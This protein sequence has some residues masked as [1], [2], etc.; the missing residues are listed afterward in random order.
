MSNSR[1]KIKQ[2]TRL[3]IQ[4]LPYIITEDVK[5]PL[6]QEELKALYKLI[7]DHVERLSN[8][9]DDGNNIDG[10]DVSIGDQR[11]LAEAQVRKTGQQFTDIR[12]AHP[13]LNKKFFCVSIALVDNQN[14]MVATSIKSVPDRKNK[15]QFQHTF[16]HGPI[17]KTCQIYDVSYH[18]EDSNTCMHVPIALSLQKYNLRQE[19]QQAK[20]TFFKSLKNIAAPSDQLLKKIQEHGLKVVNKVSELEK[21]DLSVSELQ[22]AVKALKQCETTRRHQGEKGSAN[23]LKKIAN[24]IESTPSCLARKGFGFAIQAFSVCVGAIYG[25]GNTCGLHLISIMGASLF[26]GNAKQQ[27]SALT[28]KFADTVVKHHVKQQ[29]QNTSDEDILT[30]KHIKMF[31]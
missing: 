9:I 2:T 17:P 8:S 30:G 26:G 20:E 22:T 15:N 10:S 1:D 4:G 12:N 6:S 11:T 21:E 14:N 16:T 31:S 13:S 25:I 27:F 5:H 7:E 24:D 23:T 18:Y 3:T 28:N 19:L 29:E